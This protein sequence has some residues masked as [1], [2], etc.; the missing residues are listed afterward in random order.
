G[1]YLS[2]C[3]M[4]YASTGEKRLKDIVHYITAELERCQQA[5][6][7]GYIGAIPNE[8]SI[9]GQLAR[10]EIRSGGVDLN[11]GWAPWYNTH[12]V[13]SGLVDAYYYCG[14]KKSLALVTGMADWVY[15]TIGHL[16]QEQID[17]MVRCEFGGMNDV[18]ANIY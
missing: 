7:T 11:G 8:D 3:A 14:N 15:N 9:W 16:T 6:G 5:R 2:A 4:M 12:K 1:H 13:M 18:L 10:G 17:K